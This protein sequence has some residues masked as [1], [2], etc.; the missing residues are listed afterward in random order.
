MSNRRPHE[1]ESPQGVLGSRLSVS[2]AQVAGTAVKAEFAEVGGCAC[3]READIMCALRADPAF[4]MSAPSSLFCCS[5]AV[6]VTSADRFGTVC[7]LQCERE[8]VISYVQPSSQ[9]LS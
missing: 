4:S 1:C 7:H 6:S 8:V 9:E 5:R 3:Y 2:V